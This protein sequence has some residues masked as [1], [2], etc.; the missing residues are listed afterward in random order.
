MATKSKVPFLS[1]NL[2]TLGNSEI[3]GVKKSIIL[4][5]NNLR[6]LIIG[7][8]PNLGPFNELMGFELKEHIETIKKEIILNKDKYDL[9]IVLSHLGI[10]N[11]RKIAEI[12]KVEFLV[13]NL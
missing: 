10:D 13:K 4:I 12:E 3:K 1:C 6:I 11:D 8:S 5:K 7:T 2:F 9:C